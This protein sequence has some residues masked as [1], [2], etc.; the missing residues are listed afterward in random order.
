MRRETCDFLSAKPC[1]GKLRGDLL[2]GLSPHQRHALGKVVGHEHYVLVTERKIRVGDA[3]QIGRNQACSL[4]QQLEKCV[5]RI[6]ARLTEYDGSGAAADRAAVTIDTLA[7]ALHI[8]L[9]EKSRQSPQALV[10]GNHRMGIGAQEIAVP[11][12]QQRQRDRHVALEIGFPKMTI[13]GVPSVEQ[14]LECV[15]ADCQCH[16]QPHGRPQRVAPANPIPELEDVS[17]IDAELSSAIG[18]ARH[19]D[20][21]A[22]DVRPLAEPLH[23]P[24]ACR[25]RVGE[26]LLGGERLRH[27]HEQRGGRIEIGER[28]RQMGAVDVG[29]ETHVE[30]S[31]CLGHQRI[32]HHGRTEIRS[33][34]TDVHDTRHR[35]AAGSEPGAAANCIGE[36]AHPLKRI[37]HRRHDVDALHAYGRGGTIAQR[38]V[39]DRTLLGGVDDLPGKHALRP[40]LNARCP[41]QRPQQ[42][43]G[44]RNHS[45]LG[46]IEQHFVAADREP[47]KTL[48]I[49][50]KQITHMQ[51]THLTAVRLESTPLGCSGY[52]IRH[53]RV[54]G[55]TCEHIAF[56]ALYSNPE[57]GETAATEPTSWA[58]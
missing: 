34:D 24:A 50:G 22:G 47:L 56:T 28:R 37:A 43:H 12:A 45:V 30:R 55:E 21:V 31:R 53:L 39:Q 20:E 29:D 2:D 44:L 6:G 27:D 15:H 4:M 17:G 36:T 10:V 9:L 52:V 41:S 19:G 16:R 40:L 7:V 32:R 26:R 8:E 46:V 48:L 49:L 35:P 5:L 42:R 13:H 18:L 57:S 38:R 33:A 54:P 58:P 25:V 11:H 23:Q 1:P 51:R 3:D 14:R